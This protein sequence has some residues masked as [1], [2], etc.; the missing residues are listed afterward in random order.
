[1]ASANE[2]TASA[3]EQMARYAICSCMDV[4][5]FSYTCEKM[6]GALCAMRWK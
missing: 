6:M 2:Q 1:M 5:G 4:L 3:D